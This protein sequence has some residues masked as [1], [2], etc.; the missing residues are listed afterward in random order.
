MDCSFAIHL[1]IHLLKQLCC[2]QLLAITGKASMNIHVQVLVGTSVFIW[3]R[4]IARR[5]I[6]GS[7][8]NSMFN[9]LQN[10]RIVSKSAEP[11]YL[12]P[13]GY[14]WSTFLNPHQLWGC[15]CFFLILVILIVVYRFDLC[16]PSS[17]WWGTF[18]HVFISHLYI[19]FTEVFLLIFYFNWLFYTGVLRTLC[20]FLI[21]IL[22]WIY[23]LEIFSV[24]VAFFKK[25]HV[26]C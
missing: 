26:E 10:H 7:C 3:L 8:V 12:P 20:I 15:L 1:S 25:L 2:F 23:D 13:A 22:C 14:E 19:L 24:V 4:C 16:F 9:H 11:F 21:L 18:F 17:K 5:G 6:S